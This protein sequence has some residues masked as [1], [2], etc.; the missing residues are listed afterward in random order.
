MVLHRSSV[1]MVRGV[2]QAGCFS[3]QQLV[4]KLFEAK[5]GGCAFTPVDPWLS[6]LSLSALSYNM[7][8]HF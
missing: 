6:A 1:P 5:A 7:M 3:L 4:K 8:N 2:V